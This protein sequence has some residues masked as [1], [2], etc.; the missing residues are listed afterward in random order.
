M[1]EKRVIIEGKVM[2]EIEVIVDGKLVKNLV[3]EYEW[4]KLEE[5][6]NEL[7]MY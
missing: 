6:M 7:Y 5:M 2:I 3:S 4:Y 1:E